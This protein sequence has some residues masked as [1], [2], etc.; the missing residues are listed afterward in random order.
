LL[1][2]LVLIT[3]L[4]EVTLVANVLRFLEL[5]AS[6]VEI[7]TGSTGISAVLLE[8]LGLFNITSEATLLVLLSI[9]FGLGLSISTAKGVSATD[10]PIKALRLL[11]ILGGLLGLLDLLDVL[12]LARANVDLPAGFLLLGAGLVVSVP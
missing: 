6:F 12:N 8:W 11:S 5:R 4:R 1:S 7:N 9:L 3:K 10:V 2:V